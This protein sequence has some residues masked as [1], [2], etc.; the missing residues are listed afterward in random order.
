MDPATAGPALGRSCNGGRPQPDPM[1]R[2]QRVGPAEYGRVSPE[3]P[4]HTALV[5]HHIHTRLGEKVR[6]R[7]YRI[8]EAR[9]LAVQCEVTTMLGTG[10]G[11]LEESNNEWSSLIVLVPKSDRTVLFGN[12]FW[13]LN[14]V[15]KF[16]AHPIWQVPLAAAS[17]EKTAFSTPG[18]YTT[19]GFCFSGST[20]HQ[21]PFSDSW[22]ASCGRTVST[23]L[24]IWMI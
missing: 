12:D 20:G 19:T 4:G 3:V 15:S 11:V 7:P 23:Q 17:R 16:D 2:A 9:R 22:T 24:L 6:K 10:V 13:S 8:P 18:G 21:R 5:E 1:T 14:E